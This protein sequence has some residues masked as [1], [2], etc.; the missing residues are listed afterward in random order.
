MLGPEIR[1]SLITAFVTSRLDYSNCVVAGLPK[2]DNCP[3][4]TGPECRS[5]SYNGNRP[6]RSP[7]PCSSTTPLVTHTVPDNVETITYVFWCIK[8][9]PG[10]AHAPTW[11]LQPPACRLVKPFDHQAAN[12]MKSHEWNWSSEK[13]PSHSQDSLLGTPPSDL[14]KQLDTK[15]LKTAENLSFCSCIWLTVM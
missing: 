1:T 10:A 13:E 15:I 4:S 6:A 5:P 8:W 14:Q 3:A 9:I 2:V 7:D 11:W 12:V